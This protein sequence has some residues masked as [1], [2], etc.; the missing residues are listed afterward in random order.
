VESLILTVVGLGLAV[1]ICSP[2]SVV[3]VI[4]LLDGGGRTL[5]AA[6]GIRDVVA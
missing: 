3:T 1:A 5:L 2:V 6:R 4:V